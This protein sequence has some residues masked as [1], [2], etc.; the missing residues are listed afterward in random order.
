MRL[1]TYLVENNYF[2]SRNKA[3][4]SILHSEVLVNDK[5]INK[6]SFTVG[7]NSVVKVNRGENYVS[8]GGFKMKKA[9]D[10]F[11]FDVNGL[12]VGDIGASTG[13]FTD[14]VLR[15]GA[16]KVYAVDLNDELLHSS[17]KLDERVIP[18]IKNARELS[19]LDFIDSLDLVVCD[20]SF[21]SSSIFLPI[22]S[23]IID[24][25]KHIILL[26]KPQFEA[27]EKKRYKNGIIRDDK[28][29]K[30]TINS[31]VNTAISNGLI[32]IDITSAPISQDKN[33]EFLILLKKSNDPNI[34]F[35]E[36]VEKLFVK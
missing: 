20:L 23:H 30:Q 8:L 7:E 11:N 26:I 21:I 24:N 13:G 9:L 25:E 12:V 17:L 5:I 27:N 28:I 32:P 15:H 2:E 33:R 36:K 22:L 4:W 34:S 3:S 18:I 6:P 35:N 10:D 31:V 1:D 29:H 16:K 19:K 14:C